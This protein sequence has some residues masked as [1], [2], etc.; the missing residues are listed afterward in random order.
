MTFEIIRLAEQ[1]PVQST[2]CRNVSLMIPGGPEIIESS[3]VADTID[4][5]QRPGFPGPVT[6]GTPAEIWPPLPARGPGPPQRPRPR[7]GGR[8]HRG[9]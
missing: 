7:P 9:Y 4:F 5:G 2:T 8:R 3:S 6:P 1:T